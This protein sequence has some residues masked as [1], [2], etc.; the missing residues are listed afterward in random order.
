MPKIGAFRSS[1]TRSGSARRLWV[2]DQNSI[3]VAPKTFNGRRV[4]SRNR[5]MAAKDKVAMKDFKAA[6][7]D[8]YGKEVANWA[9]STIDRNKPL[10]S[11]A[12]SDAIQACET[13]LQPSPGVAA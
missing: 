12:V 1:A 3:V 11:R 13:R 6:L 10:S 9:F 5:Q 2:T 8:A 4:S 7:K